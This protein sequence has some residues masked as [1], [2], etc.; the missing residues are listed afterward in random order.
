MIGYVINHALY[1]S[2]YHCNPKLPLPFINIASQKNYIAMYHMGLYGD[3]T[4]LDWFVSEYST[5]VNSKLEMGKGCIRFKKLDQIPYELISELISKMTAQ[6]WIV[7]YEKNY[8][9]KE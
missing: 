5:R 6:D 1:P 2:G 9:N 8:K 4:L 3:K 7:R